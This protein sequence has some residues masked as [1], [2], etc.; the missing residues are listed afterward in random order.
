MTTT[1]ELHEHWS[2]DA[3]Y[4]EAYERLEIKFE[5]AHTLIEARTRAGMKRRRRS[6]TS[7][8]PSARQ[9]EHGSPDPK[10]G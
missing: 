8:A 9:G 10:R 5:V 2:L 3:D 6:A 7:E 1:T 4:R